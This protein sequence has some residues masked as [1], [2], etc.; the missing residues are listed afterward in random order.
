MP[1]WH[2][3]ARQNFL[4]CWI[5]ARRAR[6]ARQAAD[7][8]LRARR[9]QR[10]AE[11]RHRAE[12]I[13]GGQAR[14]PSPRP[15]AAL[16]RLAARSQDRRRFVPLSFSRTTRVAVGFRRSLELQEP[17]TSRRSKEFQRFKTHPAIA[18]TFEGG[19]RLGYGARAISEGGWQVG[20]KLAFPGGAL[21]RLFGR[22]R[23]CRPHQ[24][25]AQCHAVKASSPPEHTAEAHR[26][27]PGAGHAGEL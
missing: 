25:L 21:N 22:L 14:A 11:V 16:L 13:V 7:R 10:T 5:G 17:F 3:A 8:P 6:L 12:G 23:Q 15:G 24:G 19:K 4:T 26:R 18:A 20:P 27:G 1:R 9:R 2:G